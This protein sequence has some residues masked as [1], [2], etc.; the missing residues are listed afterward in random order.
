MTSIGCIKG[1]FVW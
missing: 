1:I